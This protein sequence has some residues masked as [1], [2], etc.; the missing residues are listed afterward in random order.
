MHVCGVY[1]IPY[2]RF[3]ILLFTEE[4]TAF[5]VPPNWD[6][7]DSSDGGF[8]IVSLNQHLSEFHKVSRTF[9][10]TMPQTTYK[11][12]NIERIQN[13]V[14]WGKYYHCMIRMKND[15]QANELPL[16]HGTRGTNPADIYKCE[17]GFDMRFSNEGLWG[18]GNYFAVKA[19]Y[20]H[21]YAHSS[22]NELKQMFVALVL[23]GHVY[24]CP[25][26]N[27]KLRRPPERSTD[28][29]VNR[30]YDTVSGETQG[31]KVYITY[32]NDRA[33]PAYL[34]TYKAV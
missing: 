14:A 23:T 17:T 24:E 13:Q 10:E 12:T 15:G 22:T 31:S 20:S 18:K 25:A 5:T 7:F 30:L 28:G 3:Y 4:D 8:K 27:T 6:P 29:A 21:S 34:I 9:E 1:Y 16:F 33:Y 19:S 32:E 11:I 26:S 2:Y